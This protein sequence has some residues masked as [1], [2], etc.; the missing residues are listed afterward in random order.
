MVKLNSQFRGQ[1]TSQSSN[2]THILFGSVAALSSFPD[3][4]MQSGNEAMCVGLTCELPGSIP[5][6]YSQWSPSCS[7]LCPLQTPLTHGTPLIIG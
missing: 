7:N 4:N 3:S 6:C 5:G 2:W 1:W